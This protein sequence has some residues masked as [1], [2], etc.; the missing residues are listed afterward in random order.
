M[1]NLSNQLEVI[2]S[3]RKLTGFARQG[4]MPSS[5]LLGRSAMRLENEFA[6]PNIL[7]I[8]KSVI[9]EM[10][11]TQ[12]VCPEIAASKSVDELNIIYKDIQREQ[13][14]LSQND[15]FDQQE[16]NTPKM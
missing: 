2:L 4:V 11:K 3:A 13:V 10:L 14:M 16:Q 7:P 8:T 9:R 15:D 6:D 5:T 12:K 1:K